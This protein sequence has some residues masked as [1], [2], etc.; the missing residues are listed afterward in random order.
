MVSCQNVLRLGRRRRTYRFTGELE[1]K[2]CGLHHIPFCRLAELVG[3][4]GMDGELSINK[5]P[6]GAEAKHCVVVRL[7]L[8]DACNRCP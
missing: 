8:L 6:L 4:I 1:A 5:R 3:G 7:V 2:L